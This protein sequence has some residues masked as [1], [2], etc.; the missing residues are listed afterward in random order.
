M[1]KETD[2]KFRSSTVEADK[3][4]HAGF[5][6]QSG[7]W[8]ATQDVTQYKENAKLE[9]DKESYYGRTKNGYRKMATIPDI[10]AIK[11]LQDHHLD[12]HDPLFMQDPN[13]LKKLKTILMSEYRDLV[14]N[15]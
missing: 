11:I 12:L 2:F 13:N 14:V 7:D 6:L 10:V 4:I 1:S 3:D 9:R 8:Q 5:D 15:T